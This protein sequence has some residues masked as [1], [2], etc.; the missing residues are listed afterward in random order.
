MT[1]ETEFMRRAIALSEKTA[2]ID[3]AGGPFGCVIVRDGGILAEGANRVAAENDPTWHAE[4]DAIRQA[5]RRA[6]SPQ[7]PGA[8]LY[9]S[10]EPCPMCAA[11]AY[12]AGIAEIRYASTAEDIR[13][14][15][16]F[17]DSAVVREVAKPTG[18]RSIPTR[19]MMRAEAV[20]VWQAYRADAAAGSRDG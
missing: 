11:A 2:L 17:D 6:G 16:D 20:A 13:T 1:D 10:A 19:P 14:Y 3:R 8:I 12:W 18:A 7:L 9:T 15:S 5:C 4:M